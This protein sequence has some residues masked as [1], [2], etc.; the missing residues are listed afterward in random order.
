MMLV[1]VN[2][3]NKKIY[4]LEKSTIY[5][6]SSLMH[7]QVCEQEETVMGLSETLKLHSNT[8]QRH[9]HS[10]VRFLEPSNS[11]HPSCIQL[12]YCQR[13]SVQSQST[14]DDQSCQ[15]IQT[16]AFNSV[17]SNGRVAFVMEPVYPLRLLLHS[18]DPQSIMCV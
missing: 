15:E 5:V 13:H 6:N 7:L 2:K 9:H 17:A 18:V 3:V 11:K 1:K 14:N 12:L 16:W 10:Y 4:F 8:P